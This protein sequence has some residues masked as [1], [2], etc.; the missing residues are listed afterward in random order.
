MPLDQDQKTKVLEEARKLIGMSYDTLDCSHFVYESY[1]KAHLGYP[2]RNTKTFVDLVNSYFLP[3]NPE[4]LEAGDVIVFDGHMGI[5]DPQGCSVLTTNRECQRLDNKAPFLSSRSSK[6]R[7]PDY[8]RLGW[9]GTSYKVYR[10][11]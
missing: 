9:F 6:N 11:K 10:W 2:Y 7:G 1:V 4:Q 5:W 8:G 3:V